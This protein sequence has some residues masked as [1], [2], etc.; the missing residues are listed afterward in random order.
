MIVFESSGF[1]LL[2]CLPRLSRGSDN[3]DAGGARRVSKRAAI[4]RA[5]GCRP[6]RDLRQLSGEP[7]P[8]PSMTVAAASHFRSAATSVVGQSRRSDRV[9]TTSG[10]PL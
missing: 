1:G 2:D 8:D 6:F 9:Q 3:R 4:E 7:M 5:T 10:L